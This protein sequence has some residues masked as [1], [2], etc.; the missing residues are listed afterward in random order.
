MRGGG[1]G[2]TLEA[3]PLPL[4][5]T[6]IFSNAPRVAAF[7]RAPPTAAECPIPAEPPPRANEAAGKAKTTKK[8]KATFTEVFDMG[9]STKISLETSNARI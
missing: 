2:A 8:R 3:F 6:D 9:S 7:G 4:G 5:S 1:I